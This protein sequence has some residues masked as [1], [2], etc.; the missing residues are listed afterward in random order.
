MDKNNNKKKNTVNLTTAK[1]SSY[2]NLSKDLVEPHN[3]PGL[4]L[5]QKC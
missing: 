2:H 4:G 3:T 5:C 1:Q